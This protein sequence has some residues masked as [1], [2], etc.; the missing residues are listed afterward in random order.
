MTAASLTGNL[1]NKFIFYSLGLSAFY[2]TSG[3]GRVNPKRISLFTSI[4]I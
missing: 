4:V 1:N 2:S 3:G